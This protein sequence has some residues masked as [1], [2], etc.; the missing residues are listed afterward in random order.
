EQGIFS[1]WI[2]ACAQKRPL[3]YIGF[4]GSGRQVRDA[5]HPD[6]LAEL[7][8][9]QIEYSQKLGATTFN[10]GGGANNAMSLAQLTSWCAERF[11]KHSIESD[12]SPRPFDV[13]WLVMDNRHTTAEFNWKPKR[14]LA[15]ILDEIASH[16]ERNPH[17]LD[18]S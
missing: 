7:V 4:D 6:D 14:D 18:L 17:W 11:G 12:R 1:Y 3:K 15:S 5:L 2:N 9:T 8:A 10:I 13:P 16:A